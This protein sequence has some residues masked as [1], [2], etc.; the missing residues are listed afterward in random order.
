[1]ATW[2]PAQMAEFRGGWRNTL[3]GD[4]DNEEAEYDLGHE[5]SGEDP[6]AEMITT[7]RVSGIP[8][9]VT[10]AEFNCWFLF[11]PDFEQ[12]TL[13]PPSNPGK[14]LLGW[15]RFSTVEAAQNAILNLHQRTLTSE[16]APG[17]AFLTAEMARS[18]FK[19]RNPH[20]R[21]RV[22][23]EQPVP[24]P[25]ATPLI[26]P[27]PLKAPVAAAAA[28]SHGHPHSA[29]GTPP[30]A[31]RLQQSVPILHQPAVPLR[32]APPPG[33]GFSTLFLRSLPEGVEEPELRNYLS[34]L[35]GIFERLKLQPGQY[36]KGSMCWAK[37]ASCLDAER[38]L[39]AIALGY[40]LPSFPLERIQAEFA[41]NDLDSPSGRL[42]KGA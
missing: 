8:L 10:E 26:R 28:V 40:A 36:G 12:A 15:A 42:G 21:A 18:N 5:N 30:P 25:V 22:P 23:E 1:M 9:H 6:G 13:V 37:Y 14:F 11:A 38:A 41:K 35:G 16:Q 7:I 27:S 32:A 19:K 31:K 24:P 29:G 4:A 33:A 2:P 39:Q 17:G 34:S 3:S 20:K